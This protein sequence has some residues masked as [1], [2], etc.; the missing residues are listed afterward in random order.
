ML[1]LKKEFPIFENNPKIVYL[2]SASTTQL[3]EIVIK[4]IKFHHENNNCNL[5]GMYSL[6]EKTGEE[7]G[8]VRKKIAN[9]I[10]SNPEEIIF[11]KGT[12]ESINFI[13]RVISKLIPK[14]KDEILITELEHHSN[15]IPWQILCKNINFKLNVVKVDKNYNLDYDDLKNKISNKTAVFAFTAISNLTGTENDMKKLCRISKESGAISIIDAAQIVGHKKINVKEIDCDFLAFSGHKMYGPQGIGILYGKKEFLDKLEPYQYGGGMVSEVTF[16]SST[17][18]DGPDK[19]EA[20]TLN[21]PGII[22]LGSAIDYINKIKIEKIE[23][24]EEKLCDYAKKEL[25]KVKGIKFYTNNDSKNIISFNLKDLHP[26]DLSDELSKQGIFLRVGHMCA[27]PLIKKIGVNGL[28]RIS[29]GVY[30][31]KK[32]IDS[33]TNQLNNISSKL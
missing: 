33:L 11:T 10:G 17:Y 4:K 31:T 25:S 18:L 28:C 14:G 9:F 15:L 22:G 2:D 21:I 23:N 13:S 30:N 19:F 16:N 5:R 12:T 7:I 32:D 1:D 27:M 24:H 29:L 20:G 8:N 3:P 26:H 6:A